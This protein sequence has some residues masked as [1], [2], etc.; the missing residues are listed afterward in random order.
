[1]RSRTVRLCAIAAAI[2][3]ALH[4]TEAHAQDDDGPDGLRLLAMIS[5]RDADQLIT[6]GTA[7]LQGALLTDS[8]N[9]FTGYVKALRVATTSRGIDT[10]RPLRAFLFVGESP[11]NGLVRVSFIPVVDKGKAFLAGLEND[12]E[13]VQKNGAVISAELPFESSFPERVLVA[14]AGS[15]VIASDDF[16]AIR[17]VVE[18]LRDRNLPDVGGRNGESLIRVTFEPD[19]LKECLVA[20]AKSPVFGTAKNESAAD[21][22]RSNLVH[23]ASACEDLS[24]LHVGITPNAGG[25]E[26]SV[27][28]TAFPG[29]R[30]GAAFGSMT[31]PLSV[32]DHTLPGK[33]YLLRC[34]T[35]PAFL[36]AAPGEMLEWSGMLAASWSILGCSVGMPRLNWFQEFQPYFSGDR[37]FALT[38]PPGIE[39]VANLQAYTLRNSAKAAEKLAELVDAL[40]ASP[41]FNGRVAD[42][43]YIAGSK[44]HRIIP[45][46]TFTR[47]SNASVATSFDIDAALS[48]IMRQTAY[49]AAVAD[50]RLIVVHGPEGSLEALLPALMDKQNGGDT[51][52]RARR[53]VSGVPQ[54]ARLSGAAVYTFGN[55]I[56]AMAQLSPDVE[57]SL[58][59]TLTPDT[60]DGAAVLL[61]SSRNALRWDI[62][63]TAAEVSLIRR[64]FSMHY[65]ILQEIIVQLTL[66]PLRQRQKT[67]Q[68][69]QDSIIST[70]PVSD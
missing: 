51:F 37:L 60:G 58:Q 66:E 70:Q 54:E 2:V 63:V 19:I 46:P 44:L 49:E 45:D 25:I 7:F 53:L 56:R 6:G 55:L 41:D 62:R 22:F 24:A 64:I 15:A 27:E 35:L 42:D 68:S 12:F 8:V 26:A 1:M 31:P 29:S 65:S 30:L 57:G 23:A 10:K 20:L 38:T 48:S 61:A 36:N 52:R 43:I 34:D 11:T 14:P 18:R 50:N 47:E 21:A 69:Y 3:A 67:G 13:V 40:R 33:S 28:V 59:I 17:W 39:G 9:A 32:T 4:C 5:V 16:N